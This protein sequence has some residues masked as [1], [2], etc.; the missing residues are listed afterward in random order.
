MHQD[1]ELISI[2]G[3]VHADND[4]K[5]RDIKG[6]AKH[7]ASMPL[8]CEYCSSIPDCAG[9]AWQ[10]AGG[11]PGTCFLKSGSAGVLEPALTRKSGVTA[12]ILNA[13]RGSQSVASVVRKM[14]GET[15]VDGASNSDA[16][17]AV[18]PEQSKSSQQSPIK[19]S[20]VRHRLLSDDVTTASDSECKLPEIPPIRGIPKV[21]R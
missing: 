13:D 2:A 5:G 16:A 15:P 1:P 20:S 19:P 9:V 7:L 21:M 8:C 17:L 18:V 4:I 3:S 14:E 10:A 12:V 11:H 6:A